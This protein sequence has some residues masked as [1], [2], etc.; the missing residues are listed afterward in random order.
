MI[1]NKAPMAA[2]ELRAAISKL[3]NGLYI[4]V[5]AQYDKY[6]NASVS[7]EENLYALLLEQQNLSF[8]KRVKRKKP[9]ASLTLKQ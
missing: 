5:F 3:A 8:E 6:I 4:P 2:D 7:F 9:Q 1:D